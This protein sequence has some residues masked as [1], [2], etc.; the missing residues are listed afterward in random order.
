LGEIYV[1]GSNTKGEL[2]VGQGILEKLSPHLLEVPFTPIIFYDRP[3]L[4]FEKLLNS[5]NFSDITISGIPLHRCILRARCPKFLEVDLSAIPKSIISAL[6]HLFYSGTSRLLSKLPSEELCEAVK[7]AQALETPGLV[8]TCQRCLWD[9]ITKENSFSV[10]LKL[11]GLGLEEETEW[12]L[13]FIGK[14]KISPPPELLQR[15]TSEA[16]LVF[17]RAFQEAYTLTLPIPKLSTTLLPAL[18]DY[19]E[20]LFESGEESD[21]PLSVG[22]GVTLP[23][24][25]CLLSSWEFSKLLFHDQAH[26]LHIPLETFKKILLY[27][28]SGKLDKISFTDAHHTCF[29]SE[30]YLLHDTELYTHCLHV[31]STIKV[32]NWMEAYLL[33]IK[34]GDE[35]LKPRVTREAPPTCSTMETMNIISSLMNQIQEL[36]REEGGAKEKQEGDHTWVKKKMRTSKRRKVDNS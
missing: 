12:I 11:V 22:E 36:T 24:H 9:S 20:R 8:A 14:Q 25:K 31:Y 21:L 29:F 7:L 35:E 4:T 3:R 13:W 6:T 28:Y 15:L 1:W 10:L 16:P 18:A 17:L 26:T 30:Y 23:L 32:S 19:I 34:L 33:A 27:F 2:G 5:G